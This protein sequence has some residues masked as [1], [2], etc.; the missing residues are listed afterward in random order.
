[1]TKPSDPSNSSTIGK[2]IE[3]LF[4]LSSEN[5]E[6]GTTELGRKLNIHKATVS[7]I[8]MKL[9]EYDFVYKNKQNRK[10]GL[11]PAIHH[12]AMSMSD[13]NF[14]FVMEV[15]R[16][17]IDELSDILEETVALE[18]WLG[19]ST[20]PTYSAIPQNNFKVVM[21]PG[22][23][24][25]AHAAA[26][27]KSILA[28]THSDRADML[29]NSELAK[30]TENTVTDKTQLKALLSD[31]VKQGYSVDH[32]EMH[33]GICAIAAPIFNHVRQPIAALVVLVSSSRA[34]K[35]EDHN[36]I[37]NLKAKATLISK[38]VAA[39]WQLNV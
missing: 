35:L 36:L 34:A 38:N 25:A 28:Y 32:E 26:G 29:L 21:P 24:L 5:S 37:N 6:V 12:L 27:A 30:I 33:L 19:N 13:I 14:E 4:A 16:P 10:Y 3:L 23:P 15:A 22:E 20:V 39:N 11:G 9:A 2:A 8:L 1:M 17:H 31:Y 18:V 7:R